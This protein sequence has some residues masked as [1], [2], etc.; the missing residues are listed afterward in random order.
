M[1]PH[2]LKE[3]FSNWI[4]L[5]ARP[6]KYW[7]KSHIS[8]AISFSWEN[9]TTID[10]NNIPYR[11]LSP[12]QMAEALGKL[13]ISAESMILIYGD[14]DKSWGGEGW[15]FWLFAWLGHKGEV[16]LL[17]G[18]IQAWERSK[19]DLTG[20]AKESLDKDR[21]VESKKKQSIQPVRYIPNPVPSI[22]I[23]ARE[24]HDNPDKYQLVDTRSTIEWFKGHLPDAVHIPWEKFFKG[25]D[26][27]P[28][29]AEELKSLLNKNGLNME[30]TV[31]YYCTGG[32][33]SGYAW[34]VHELAALKLREL[35]ETI[36][37]EGGTAEWE[38]VN[39]LNGL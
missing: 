27:S 7:E 11:V 3:N 2:Q 26:R 9:Y 19:F 34:M 4:I 30:K 13:G 10:S 24:I 29:N 15:G 33:R 23:S 16:G 18:G 8:G 35:P 1:E 38:A 20:R 12:E 17:K 37:F 6:V 39:N 36:N 28:L 5:D 32:I 25:R 14:A 31:V 22:N 21:P